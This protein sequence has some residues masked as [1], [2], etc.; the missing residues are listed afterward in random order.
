MMNRLFIALKV[1]REALRQIIS[2]RDEIYGIDEKVR[3]ELEQKLHITLKF[4]GD[5][6][7]DLIPAILDKLEEISNANSAFDPE[8]SK[9]GLFYRKAEP[10]ILWIGTTDNR[11]LIS[12]N[13]SVDESMFHL[14][15]EKE[16]R[17]FKS[18]LTLLRV[19]G[20]EDFKKLEKFR[21]IEFKPI[22]FRAQNIELIK[23][24][25]KPTGSV[26][27]TIQSLNMK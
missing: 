2:L 3:W 10:K 20:N 14:G 13:C 22:K 9:F 11:K 12:L 19:K 24:V 6:N 27:T 16:T 21:Q 18:H 1:P 23:S 7:S 5:V 17:N 4:L 26:Y 15:F 25:L 8:F